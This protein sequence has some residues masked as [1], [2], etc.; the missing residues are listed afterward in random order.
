MDILYTVEEKYLQATEELN[1]GELPKA[2]HLLNEIIA[3]DP[4]YARAYFQL[5]YLYHYQFKNY[6]TA[7]YYY[8]QCIS[9]DAAFPDVYTHYLDLL[10]TLKMHK[11]VAPV[12]EKALVIP[13][14]CEACIYEHL[15]RHAEEQKDFNTAKEKYKLA[16]LAAV[17]K[18]ESELIQEHLK[19][20]KDK[21]RANQ[22]MIYAYQE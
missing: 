13:G 9:L 22:A 10:I 14:V 18:N 7:G 1:Y 4:D 6:Q 11:Q 20:V 3:A 17:G 12:A 16:A 8:K 19:R 5:G 15:G 2:L 21:Q